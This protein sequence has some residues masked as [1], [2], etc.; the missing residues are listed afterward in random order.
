M[1]LGNPIQKQN[2]SRIISATATSGQVQFTVT[3]GY[4]VNNIGVFRNGVR[5]SNADD[6]TASDGSTVSLN[7][8]A[9]VGD[10]L[11]FHCWEKFT[12]SNAI[13]GAAST[14][15][16]NGNLRVTGELYSDDFKPDNILTTGITTTGNLTVT[17]GYVNASD[18]VRNTRVGENAG[19]S[20]DG[21]NAADNTLIG[22]DS[23]TAI[24]TGDGN[25]GLGAY[26]LAS[27]TTAGNNTAV[28]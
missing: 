10:A 7:V 6:F 27:K 21:T 9:D 20:F 4:T 11:D 19:D 17:S 23:G 28:G 25:T 3:G 12:V 15:T 14:Q 16:I 13:V 18:S 5:L 1:P 26:S 8:A 24:T 2:D 22:Y